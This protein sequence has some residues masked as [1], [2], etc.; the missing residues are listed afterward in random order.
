MMLGVL[1]CRARI[2]VYYKFSWMHKLVVLV[3]NETDTRHKDV[4]NSVHEKAMIDCLS[5]IAL[6]RRNPT[7][8]NRTIMTATSQ[9][10]KP[11]IMLPHPYTTILLALQ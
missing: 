2:R 7:H 10:P 8:A 5:D 3:R 11:R 6:R 1:V 4:L 9:D